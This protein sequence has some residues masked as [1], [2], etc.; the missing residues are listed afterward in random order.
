MIDANCKSECKSG[1]FGAQISRQFKRKN[2][3]NPPDFITGDATI[4]FESIHPLRSAPAS[5]AAAFI[6]PRGSPAAGRFLIH[7]SIHT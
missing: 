2:G 5:I 6:P 3:T 4:L 7:P 1:R